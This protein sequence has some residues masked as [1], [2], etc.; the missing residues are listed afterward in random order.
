[1]A[2]REEFVA[3]SKNGAEVWYDAEDSHAAT[4]I[5]DTPELKGLAAEVIARSDLVGKYL[6]F[7]ID[8][9]RIVGTSDLVKNKPGDAIVYAKRLNRD[10]YTVFNKSRGPE[11]SSLVTVAVEKGDDDK[12]KL[13]STWIGPSDLPSFPGTERETPDSK[14]FWAEHSLAW[15]R[16]EI[17]PGTETTVCPW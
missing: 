16:Q 2:K 8:M 14:A 7:H 17:Q 12:Y 4:H 10:N 13:V 15:G 1:M 11:P 9:G 3:I 5:A 6:Q